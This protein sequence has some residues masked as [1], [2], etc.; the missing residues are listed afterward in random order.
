MCKVAPK[1]FFIKS[2]ILN[3]CFYSYS[4]IVDIGGLSFS[5]S[6]KLDWG[7]PDV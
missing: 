5:E 1:L 6:L 4:G 3:K 7:E 2:D